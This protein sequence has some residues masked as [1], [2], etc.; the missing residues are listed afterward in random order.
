M[1]ICNN[2]IRFHWL[3]N[4]NFKPIGVIHTAYTKE[5]NNA[6][7]QS[8]EGDSKEF[9]VE[10]YTEHTKRLHL[11]DSFTYIYVIYYLHQVTKK[12]KEL[13]EP[14]MAQ[15][16]KVGLFASRSPNRINPI[17]LSVVK[18][19]KIQRNK[20][21]I[22]GIDAFDNTPV[23]DIKPYIKKLDVKSDANNGWVEK[24]NK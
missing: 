2:L 20:L 18:L 23:I 11:L 15:N 8:T 1:Y 6:P 22:S 16:T 10:I 24:E 13:V 7:F 19:K 12:P 21:L 5:K 14:P 4:F 9:Y 3:M 17:G